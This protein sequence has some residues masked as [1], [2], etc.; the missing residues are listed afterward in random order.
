MRHTCVGLAVVLMAV[1]G[2]AATAGAA[3]GPTTMSAT[4]C[5]SGSPQTGSFNNVTV[6][7][8]GYCVLDNAFV[9]GNG[10]IGSAATFNAQNGTAIVG[11]VTGK[12]SDTIR[13][14]DTTHVDGDVIANKTG[15][16]G[17]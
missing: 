11:N 6:P 17:N 12:S 2:G 13:L 9:G 14:L 7:D 1:L 15:I 16:S 10:V 3:S 5:N 4:T 8:N